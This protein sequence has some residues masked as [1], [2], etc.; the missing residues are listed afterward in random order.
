VV[1]FSKQA[2]FLGVHATSHNPPHTNSNALSGLGCMIGQSLKLKVCTSAMVLVKGQQE[3][4]MDPARVG[5]I[6]LFEENKS[7]ERARGA[8]RI[9]RR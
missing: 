8:H 6:K 2:D 3:L 7:R 4:D 5:K 9:C 1:S